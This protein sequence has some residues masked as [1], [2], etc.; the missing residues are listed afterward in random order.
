MLLFFIGFVVAWLLIAVIIWW[1]A[2]S[3]D[4]FSKLD[5]WK[6]Y[7][8]VWP[9]VPFIVGYIAVRKIQMYFETEEYYIVKKY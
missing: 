7:L 3:Y 9:V 8:L 2:Y 5:P 1:E 6:F 4:T